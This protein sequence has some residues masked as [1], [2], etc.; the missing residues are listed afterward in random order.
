MS[1]NNLKPVYI[2]SVIVAILMAGNR[3]GRTGLFTTYT[4]ITPSS[5]PPGTAMT[6]VTLFVAVRCWLQRWSCRTR[7]AAGIPDLDGR[8]G[9]CPLQLPVLPVRRRL[10]RVLPGLRGAVHLSDLRPDPGAV[11]C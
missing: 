3:P 11:Q 8:A 6:L 2:L 1:P 7:L 5:P 4:G 10:Q 9:I